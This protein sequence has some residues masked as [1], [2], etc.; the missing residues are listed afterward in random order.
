M[1]EGPPAGQ[2]IQA[3]LRI[4]PMFR[5]MEADHRVE[6]RALVRVK[7]ATCHHVIGQAACLIKRP[8]LKSRDELPL[9]DQ[10][11][12]K[13]KQSEQKVPLGRKRRAPMGRGSGM[14]PAEFSCG[15][16]KARWTGKS[17]G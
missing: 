14:S 2:R 7:V 8:G 5:Q 16:I 1:G 3:L 11:V 15:P 6:Y 9:A 17:R 10:S 4:T 13:R 12:L